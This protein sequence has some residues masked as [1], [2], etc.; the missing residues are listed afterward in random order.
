MVVDE[1]ECSMTAKSPLSVEYST[2]WEAT[3]SMTLLRTMYCRPFETTDSL[4]SYPDTS[5]SPERVVV[6]DSDNVVVVV[7]GRVVVV[8]A[9]SRLSSRSRI[10]G[11]PVKSSMVMMTATTERFFDFMRAPI[12]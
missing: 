10:A 12:F 3:L 8:D 1:P 2:V 11:Q 9:G 6:S 5:S 7:G 4:P